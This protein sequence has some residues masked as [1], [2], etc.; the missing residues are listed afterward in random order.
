MLSIKEDRLLVVKSKSNNNKRKNNNYKNLSNKL[1]FDLELRKEFNFR[2][3]E[4]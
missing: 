4:N 2:N 3:F 1:W